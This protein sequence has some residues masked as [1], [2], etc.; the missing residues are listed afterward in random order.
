MGDGG[1]RI[2]LACSIML[3]LW[4]GAE[5]A[6][7]QSFGYD[8]NVNYGHQ[9]NQAAMTAV[10]SR[11]FGVENVDPFTGDVDPKKVIFSWTTNATLAVSIKGRIIL[12]DTY[13]NRV[14]VA[15][16]SSQA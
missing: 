3:G 1:K 9:V 8:Q 7:A 14:E 5:G 10:R 13:I 12:L 16:P 15:P 2:A 11:F 4:A 6:A